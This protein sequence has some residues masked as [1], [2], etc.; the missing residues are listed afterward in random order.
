MLQN[1]VPMTHVTHIK[2]QTQTHT[3]EPKIHQTSL[4]SM[5]AATNFLSSS[6]TFFSSSFS[7]SNIADTTFVTTFC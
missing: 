1:S 2:T 6:A 7:T 5:R 4:H 3:K